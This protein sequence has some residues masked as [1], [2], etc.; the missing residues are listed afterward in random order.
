MLKGYKQRSAV[1]QKP[2]VIRAGAVSGVAGSGL[3]FAVVVSLSV[4]QYEFMLSIGWR[5]LSDPGG[6]WPSGLALGPYGRVM[7]DAFLA[8]GLLL[9]VFSAGLE[10]S[11]PPGPRLDSGLLFVSAAAIALLAFETDPILRE[12]P[13]SLHGFIH[14]AAFVTF[15]LSVLPAL[16]LLRGRMR[17]SVAWRGHARYTLATGITAGLSLLVGGPAYYLFVACLLTWFF[18]SGLKLSGKP[19]TV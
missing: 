15:T 3:L 8:S 7:D 1:V 11:L 14:D 2:A 13:R 4:I 9:A 5:P 12:G 6:A 19:R 16:F 18:A 17:K 10:R